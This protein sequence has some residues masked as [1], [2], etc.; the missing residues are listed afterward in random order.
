MEAE[1]L[2]LTL[3]DRAWG[4]RL[5]LESNQE[6]LCKKAACVFV[7]EHRSFSPSDYLRQIVL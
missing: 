4:S 7:S 5:Y 2:N 6:S 3:T 1:D